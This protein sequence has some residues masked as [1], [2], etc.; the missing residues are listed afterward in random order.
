MIIE[1][2]LKRDGLFSTGDDSDDR[3]ACCGC[4]GGCG[5]SS[6]DCDD[7]RFCLSLSRPLGLVLLLL[8]SMLKFM[9]GDQDEDE[10][11][12]TNRLTMKQGRKRYEVK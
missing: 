7:C 4:C 10:D 8:R 11:L 2:I 9:I 12:H 3:E 5:C 1:L 6:C